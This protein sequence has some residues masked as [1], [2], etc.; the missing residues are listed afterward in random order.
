MT[1]DTF[2][3]VPAPGARGQGAHQRPNETT[4]PTKRI[5]SHEE[6]QLSLRFFFVSFDLF[7]SSWSLDVVI[8]KHPA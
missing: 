1:H 5:E 3:T 6:S 8:E 2:N 4:K 7:V